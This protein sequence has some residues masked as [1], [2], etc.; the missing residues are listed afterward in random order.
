LGLGCK[1][2]RKLAS[3]AEKVFSKLWEDNYRLLN[4]AAQPGRACSTQDPLSSKHSP[5]G[6]STVGSAEEEAAVR[7]PP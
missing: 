6:G 7:K 4:D 2:Q 5:T 3:V 1:W